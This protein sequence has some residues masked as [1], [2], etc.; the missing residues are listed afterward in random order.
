M[1]AAFLQE[2]TES[3]GE[4][5]AGLL[6]LQDGEADREQLNTIF[7]AV[8]SIKGGAGMFGLGELTRFAHVFETA[9]DGLRAGRLEPTSGVLKVLLRAAD[10]LADLVTA[11]QNATPV[12]E[13]ACAG[14]AAELTALEPVDQTAGAGDDDDGFTP[15]MADIDSMFEP[16]A[17]TG[18]WRID[19]V[20]RAA[21]YESAN[22]PLPFLQELQRF[23]DYRVELDADNLPPL[24]Q[25]DPEEAYLGWTVLLD[26]PAGAEDIGEIFDFV[27]GVCE[28]RIEQDVSAV[29]S[30]LAEVA[31][32]PATAP[33]LPVI[34]VPA[35]RSSAD[36]VRPT[37]ELAN[38]TI[39]VDLERVDR[40]INLV[41]E[42]VIS[43]A[44]LTERASQV[45]G[46]AGLAVL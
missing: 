27:E 11:A 24:D 28:L 42:L 34:G 36:V 14:V 5:E 3:L 25:L 18:S 35:S 39:R 26:S 1:R 46:P 17:A 20:P 40:L 7:R 22:E 44:T 4:L 45:G 37:K 32:Q 15:V 6:V 23:G 19:F 43:E 21:L 10:I 9:L 16:V 41:S 13:V 31:D 38:P 29:I 2:C 8:H 12:D 33:D 30:G